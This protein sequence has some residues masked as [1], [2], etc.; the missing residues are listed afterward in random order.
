M[1]I[2]MILDFM[3]IYVIHI[4]NFPLQ[5]L[6]IKNQENMSWSLNFYNNILVCL[7]G[8][9]ICIHSQEKNMKNSYLH[10]IKDKS[11]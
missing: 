5:I 8:F 3:E 6:V 4:L 2:R 1:T 7:H 10:N 11:S 9:L